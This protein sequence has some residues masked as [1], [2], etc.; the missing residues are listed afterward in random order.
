MS[1][2]QALRDRPEKSQLCTNST[3][4]YLKICVFFFI[5]KYTTSGMFCLYDHS[6]RSPRSKYK[7]VRKTAARTRCSPLTI[8]Q[9]SVC[10]PPPPLAPQHDCKFCFVLVMCFLFLRKV[11]TSRTAGR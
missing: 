1:V 3:G 7:N 6:I 2:V 5:Y 9:T 10:F 8:G 11:K 4:I